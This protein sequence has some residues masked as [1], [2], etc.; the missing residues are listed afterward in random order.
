[1]LLLL[2]VAGLVAAELVLPLSLS[3]CTYIEKSFFHWTFKLWRA[4]EGTS[5]LNESKQQWT[6]L[7]MVRND[8]SWWNLDIIWE[9]NCTKLLS[10]HF[11]SPENDYTRSEYYIKSNLI[12]NFHGLSTK[13]NFLAVHKWTKT[14]NFGQQMALLYFTSNRSRI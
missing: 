10:I 8:G 11:L 7:R 5:H 12:R 2:L 3:F 14:K 6:V 9:I 13:D 1:M 4:F